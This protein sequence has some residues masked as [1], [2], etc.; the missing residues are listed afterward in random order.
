MTNGAHFVNA[1]SNTKRACL[2]LRV[3]T[4]SKIKCDTAFNQNPAV[5]EQPLRDLIAQRGWQ[6]HGVYSDRASGAKERRP[7]LAEPSQF[8]TSEAEIPFV[9][10]K[11]T[12]KV[13]TT[14]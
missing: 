2:Y 7:G 12:P 8:G 4:A 13:S 9:F 6:L 10:N 1:G 11:G 5:Q 3:S 14:F